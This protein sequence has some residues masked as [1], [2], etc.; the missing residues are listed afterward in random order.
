[1]CFVEDPLGANWTFTILYDVSRIRG[2][3]GASLVLKRVEEVQLNQG[4]SAK[5]SKPSGP[6]SYGLR[7]CQIFHGSPSEK[8]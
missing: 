5:L 7:G 2:G 6:K 4:L 8:V 1:M 3:G